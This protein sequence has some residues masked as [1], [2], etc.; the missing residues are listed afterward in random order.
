M[1]LATRFWR[2]VLIIAVSFL[3]I[4][5]LCAEE[6]PMLRGKK[7]TEWIDQ[8]QNGKELRDRQAALLAIQLIGPRK[9]RKV[10][11]ALIAALRENS[12]ESIRA[13]AARALGNIGRGARDEDDIPI[14]KIRDALAASLRSDK[15]PAVRRAAA[16]ALGQMKGRAI[17]VVDVLAL[18]LKDTD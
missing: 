10:T 15:K 4:A 5:P 1:M 6:E 7:L 3:G 9:S 12:E 18:A 8:L 16:R 2:M 11:Q 14:D 17:G 13:G